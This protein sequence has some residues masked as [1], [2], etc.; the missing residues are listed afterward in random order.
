MDGKEIT[1]VGLYTSSLKL[2]VFR[3]S[4]T[5]LKLTRNTGKFDIIPKVLNSCQTFTSESLGEYLYTQ[6]SR[7]IWSQAS[8]VIR[9]L[10]KQANCEIVGIGFDAT[11]SLVL[12]DKDKN[13]VEIRDESSDEI[14]DVILW[15]WY[16]II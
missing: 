8:K 1:E 11:C 6:S 15:E 9:E 2:I 10:V 14:F 12:L 4:F 13:G 5:T 16:S 3:R 7:D